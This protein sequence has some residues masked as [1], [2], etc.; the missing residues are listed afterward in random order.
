M[1][2]ILSLLKRTLRAPISSSV[3]GSL[4]RHGLSALGALL[5]SL[6]LDPEAVEKF[7]SASEPI[8]IGL[9]AILA[10]LL[11]SLLNKKTEKEK[12]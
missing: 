9:A 1:K 11:L 4:I 6:S 7:I 2:L 5:L 10:S 12:E 3:I 8:A